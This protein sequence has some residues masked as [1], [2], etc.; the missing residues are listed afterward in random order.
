MEIAE[1]TF[2]NIKAAM[3]N[4]DVNMGAGDA[5]GSKPGANGDLQNTEDWDA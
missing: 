1:G 5:S 4:A 3:K 2:D